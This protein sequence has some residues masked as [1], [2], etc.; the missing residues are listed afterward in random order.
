MLLFLFISFSFLFFPFPFLLAC[1]C[2]DM[3][4]VSS[5]SSL[6]KTWVHRYRKAVRE[7]EECISQNP[8]LLE[9]QQLQWL[10]VF[11]Q[12]LTILW[13]AKKKKNSNSWF[14][15]KLSFHL[16]GWS[17]SED[18]HRSCCVSV[19]LPFDQALS[20]DRKQYAHCF[21]A[22]ADCSLVLIIFWDLEGAIKKN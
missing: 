10:I 3:I 5:R 12:T 17:G 18:R 7:N 9:N 6:M 19:S 20:P 15:L 21:T 1:Y 11:L 8:S 2:R 22:I 13:S 16:S 4:F 14:S